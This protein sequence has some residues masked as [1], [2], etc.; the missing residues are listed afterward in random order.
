MLHL[1]A[2]IAGQEVGTK[3]FQIERATAGRYPPGR[4][5]MIGDAPGD[6]AAARE[7]G[8]LFYP[9]VP[10]R[11]EPSW[12]RLHDEAYDRFLAGDYAGDYAEALTR[13]FL[14]ALPDTPPWK[15]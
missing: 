5:L 12:R 2:A 9:I 6:L 13:G 8:A 3:A 4:L 11:E 10:G 14:D 15:R 1:V 7:A